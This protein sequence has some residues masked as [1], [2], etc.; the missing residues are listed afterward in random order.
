MSQLEKPV[1][2]YKVG[3]QLQG[4]S[5]LT[6]LQQSALAQNMVPLY[7]PE[8]ASRHLEV[9]PGKEAHLFLLC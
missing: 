7:D 5:A 2:E 1:S 4:A 3:D 8:T 9:E 6:L